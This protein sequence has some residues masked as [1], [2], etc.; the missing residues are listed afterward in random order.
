MLSV[1]IPAWNEEQAVP[2]AAQRVARVLAGAD[3]D[4]ELIFVDDGSSDGTWAAVEAVRALSPAW[5]RPGETPAP[6]WTATSSTPRKSWW[7]WSGCGS[8]AMR[9]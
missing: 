4:Y 2:L 3:I 1:I 8:G 7:R 9:W 5:R 6:C